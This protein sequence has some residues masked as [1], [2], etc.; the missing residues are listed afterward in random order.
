MIKPELIGIGREPCYIYYNTIY[1][2]H[3]EDRDFIAIRSVVN[4]LGQ[5]SISYI[6]IDDNYLPVIDFIAEW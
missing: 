2:G 5:T 6:I 4:W 1:F 3:D